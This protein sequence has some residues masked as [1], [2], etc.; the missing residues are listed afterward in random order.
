MSTTKDHWNYN[1]MNFFSTFNGALSQSLCQ[2]NQSLV[3]QNFHNVTLKS[4]SRA[5]MDQVRNSHQRN[6]TSPMWKVTKHCREKLVMGCYFCK[7][8]AHL[9]LLENVCAINLV[10]WLRLRRRL[11]YIEEWK[12]KIINL[13]TICYSML[14]RTNNCI[15]SFLSEVFQNICYDL[16]SRF[17]HLHLKDF[18]NKKI[19]F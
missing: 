4:Y 3:L 8:T 19:I 6:S 14:A 13:R 11:R 5:H 10:M 7:F 1:L 17:D 16:S 15:F 9:Q 2:I 12:N 18:S